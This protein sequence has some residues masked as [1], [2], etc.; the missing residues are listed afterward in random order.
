MY[1]L[2]ICIEPGEAKIVRA[3]RLGGGHVTRGPYMVNF[4]DGYSDTVKGGVFKN[5]YR[6]LTRHEL[7]LIKMTDQELQVSAI[8]DGKPRAKKD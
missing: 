5:R 8:S 2:Y 7:N 1:N 4:P 6:L 3:K